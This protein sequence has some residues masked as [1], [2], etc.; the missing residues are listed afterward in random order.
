HRLI[1]W[2]V[3]V[4]PAKRLYNYPLGTCGNGCTEQGRVGAGVKGNNVDTRQR[5]ARHRNVLASHGAPCEHDSVM[6]DDTEEP[7][8]ARL[9][10][11]NVGCVGLGRLAR[12]IDLAIEHDH[13]ALAQRRFGDADAARVHEIART[14]EVAVGCVA[15]RPDKNDG[16]VA[17]H[18]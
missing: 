16:L 13:G 10:G 9:E 1:E 17:P 14:I 3:N 18:G 12:R 2:Y 11:L 8:I 15:L 6:V 7:E 5:I 4:A